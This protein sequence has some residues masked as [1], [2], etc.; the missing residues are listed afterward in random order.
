MLL[1]HL[2]RPAAP[3]AL[4]A[5]PVMPGPSMPGPHR[6]TCSCLR[7]K[8]AA[9]PALRAT[10][11]CRAA[12]SSRPPQ[13]GALCCLLCLSGHPA[14]R[15]CL[16]LVAAAGHFVLPA[17]PLTGRPALST[18]AVESTPLKRAIEATYGA[19][20]PKA[21][22]PFVFLVSS[23]APAWAPAPRGD[24]PSCRASPPAC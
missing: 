18:P 21:S 20:L 8:S 16:S 13:S 7:P 10:P 11:P 12:A 17:L 3:T 19:V 2:P 23:W 22:R 1:G 15:C 24:A 5:L 4:P 14:L 6:A 9:Y